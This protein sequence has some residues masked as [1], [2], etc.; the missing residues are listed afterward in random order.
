MLSC[1]ARFSRHGEKRVEKHEEDV[2]LTLDM[3]GSRER[4][5]ATHQEE[6]RRLLR[7]LHDGLGPMLASL[8]FGLDAACNP[9]THAPEDASA[10]SLAC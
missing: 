7:N 9:L 4:L 3:Y 5:V 1:S 2:R 8:T 6:R 10:L